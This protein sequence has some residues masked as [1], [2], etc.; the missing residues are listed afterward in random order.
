[1]SYTKSN[2][3]EELRSDLFGWLPPSIYLRIVP[4]YFRAV[5]PN[6]RNCSYHFSMD[7]NGNKIV[8]GKN[9]KFYFVDHRRLNRY[10]YP[11]G[12]ARIKN[13]MLKKYCFGEC[14]IDA[15]DVVVEIGANIGEFTLAAAECGKKIYAFE[16]DP[17]CIPCLALNTQTLKNV[18]IVRYGAT[19]KNERR[20]FFL[21]S[22]DADSSFIEPQTY[23][24]ILEIETMRLDTWMQEVGLP[25][26]DFL[27]IE[28][29]GG[30][31]E[32]LIGLGKRINDVLKISVDGGPERQGKPT[33]SEVAYY[34]SDRGFNINVVRY[35]VYAWK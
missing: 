13:V 6:R 35:Q 34:L 32:V 24:D 15:D 2:W 30:E 20:N 28:A 26:I 9:E 7:R 8:Y 29:E 5:N 18:E 16:P 3:K 11:N 1:M 19:D 23:S 25:R 22:E 27:K 33:C 17:K 14:R 31:L 4:L 12:L 21:S 10:M